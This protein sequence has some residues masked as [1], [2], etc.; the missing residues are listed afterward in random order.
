MIAKIFLGAMLRRYITKLIPGDHLRKLLILILSICLPAIAD[1]TVDLAF[2]LHSSDNIVGGSTEATVPFVL[3]S[4]LINGQVGIKECDTSGNNTWCSNNAYAPMPTSQPTWTYKKS[5]TGGNCVDIASAVSTPNGLLY[6]PY[7][8]TYKLEGYTAQADGSYNIPARDY[9]FS[10]K[11]LNTLPVGVHTFPS[12]NIDKLIIC[13]STPGYGEEVCSAQTGVVSTTYLAANITITVPQSCTV[14]SGQ[15]VNVDLGSA[16]GSAFVKGG[17]GNSPHGFNEK[18]VSVPI[19]CQGGGAGTVA[20]SLHG[21]NATNYASNLA[22]SNADVGVKLVDRT[23]GSGNNGQPI[24]PN[25]ASSVSTIQLGEDGTGAA[26]L[27]ISPVWLG[28]NQPAK[29]NYTAQSYLQ[30]DYQ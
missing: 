12:M 16:S 3:G 25:D 30:L 13:K 14:N 6:T 24:V 9:H 23:A 11:L 7:K 28:A 22:T 8:S 21:T 20:M 4:T 2:T 26:T 1:Q 5:C 29:G 15:T 10:V 17:A 19:Q 27:G 18:T